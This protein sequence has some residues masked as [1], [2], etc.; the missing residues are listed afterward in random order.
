MEVISKKIKP[1]LRLAGSKFRKFDFINKIFIKSKKINF[2]ELFG[3]TGI[4]STNIKNFHPN[5]NVYLNDLDNLFPLTK[6]IVETNLTTYEGLGKYKTK[7]AEEFFISR[8]K[9]GLWNK[10]DQYNLILNKIS[11]SHLD[12]KNV[13]ISPNSFVYIDP[14]YFKRNNLYKN[15]I[16]HLE[17]LRFINNLDKSII[18]L[19][20]YD[21]DDIVIQWYKNYYFYEDLFLYSGLKTKGRKTKKELWIS[22]KNIF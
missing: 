11:I 17:L 1:V 14:P 13:K 4:V 2:Y 12:Y 9:N 7:L 15:N 19:L 10:V 5:V 18:W 3:G 8:V 21:F 16:N 22:N 6:E 20:S